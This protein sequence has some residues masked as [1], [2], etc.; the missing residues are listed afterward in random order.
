LEGQLQRAARFEIVGQLAG[1]VIHDF[2]NV[3]TVI[4]G[5]AEELRDRPNDPAQTTELAGTIGRAGEH[6][7]AL[8]R[9]QLNVVRQRQPALRPLD[10]NAAVADTAGTLVRLM[11]TRVAVRVLPEAHLPP[12][13]ADGALVLQIVLNLTANARDAMPNGGTFTL[14]TS[15]P[16]PGVVRLTATDTGVGMTPDVCARAF[17]PGFT[18][19]EVEKGTGLGLYIVARAVES[20]GGTVRVRSDLGR[21]TTFEIDLP[22]A[23][24]A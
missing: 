24:P 16:G 3:L 19:K 6:G 11:G 20:L 9:Q 2:N 1:G 8:V 5:A 22:A 17:D 23:P 14:A 10:R 15:A 7:T 4:T 21:G 12:V 13:L 18:T